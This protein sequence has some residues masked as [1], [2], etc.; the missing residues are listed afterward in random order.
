VSGNNPAAGIR[1]C[2]PANPL[3]PPSCFLR[4]YTPTWP[5]DIRE[6]CRAL[7]TRHPRRA[8]TASLWAYMFA[9]FY[10]LHGL[11]FPYASNTHTSAFILFRHARPHN[12]LPPI[13]LSF[14]YTTR[15]SFLIPHRSLNRPQA[16]TSVPTHNII[17][18]Y[19]LYRSHSPRS[20]R[21][22]Y[23]SS[24]RLLRRSFLLYV[25]AT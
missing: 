21:V 1:T 22:S 4:A 13:S 18:R 14:T 11:L 15:R 9:F 2:R 25:I 16:P 19:L 3:E 8:D 24:V 7:L 17:A 5:I 6:L 23:F 20:S 12:P 10:S